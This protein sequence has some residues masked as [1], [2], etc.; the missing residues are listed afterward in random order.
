MKKIMICAMAIM[1]TA[2]MMAFES[3]AVFIQ[4]LF[5]KVGRPYVARGGYTQTTAHVSVPSVQH[6]MRSE[7]SGF[8]VHAQIINQVLTRETEYKR[9]YDVFYTVQECSRLLQDVTRE[10]YKR[11]VG[12]L[13]AL[14]NNAF[15]FVRYEYQ[16]PQYNQF[17]GVNAFLKHAITKDGIA[18]DLFDNNMMLV[19]ADLS[20]FGNAGT[21]V[22]STWM[23]FNKPEQE[24]NPSMVRASLAQVLASYGY[25]DAYVNKLLELQSYLVDS[26][27]KQ[28]ADLLQIFVP[29]SMVNTIGYV[30]WR[31]AIP[32]DQQLIDAILNS[33]GITPIASREEMIKAVGN[34][35]RLYKNGDVNAQKAV[36]DML[37]RMESG[38]FKL[39]QYLYEYRTQPQ[40]LPTLNFAQARLL[41][42]NKVMLNPES[43]VR[44][45]RY[46]QLEPAKEA[47]YKI[48]LERIFHQMDIEKQARDAIKVK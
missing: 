47:A 33:Q 8:G 2:Q 37:K 34:F 38:S 7:L 23:R 14:K 39:E 27:G 18:F 17:S 25:S 46:S 35:N 43:G 45:Y 3:D 5:N 20:L 31:L 48:E 12:E 24:C 36:T 30:S 26:H 11:Q 10:L 32:Y 4:Q 42:T 29:E 41:I 21:G 28:L 40:T 22:Y 13:G 16:K 19:P 1:Q 9:Q 15:Q 6:I 44:I